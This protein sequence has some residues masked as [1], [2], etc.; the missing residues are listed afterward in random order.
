LSEAATEGVVVRDALEAERGAIREITLRAYREY[1]RIMA[2][3]AWEGLAGAVEG[4]LATTLPAER[5][6]AVREREIIGSVMLFP[7]AADVY[8]GA[9]RAVPWPELR[10]LAVA[11]SAR[12]SGVGKRL[13][14][15]VIRR[16]RESGATDLG[17]HTSTSMQSAVRM[18]E[19]LGF[20]RDP[21]NDFQPEGA[22]LVLAYRLPLR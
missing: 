15:E 5:I 11:Q 16:A 21:E 7:A 14:E 9:A 10:L 19:R 12:G 1:A 3:T 18:Y 4:A 13:V 22:E 17:L 6:V 2:P 8:G 20:L